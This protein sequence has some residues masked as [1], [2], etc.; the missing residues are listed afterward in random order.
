MGTPNITG[1]FELDMGL[2]IRASSPPN[3]YGHALAASMCC[4]KAELE[5]VGICGGCKDEKEEK[6]KCCGELRI[7]T[8]SGTFLSNQLR[9]SANAPVPGCVDYL[10]EPPDDCDVIPVIDN[11]D[12]TYTV[13]YKW[14]VDIPVTPRTTDTNIRLEITALRD[15]ASPQQFNNLIIATWPQGYSCIPGTPLLSGTNDPDNFFNHATPDWRGCGV[16]L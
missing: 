10:I 9:P 12:G 2:L 8:T 5:L 11:G 14:T 3:L 6:K 13:L 4:L 1:T 16:R 7:G 15:C